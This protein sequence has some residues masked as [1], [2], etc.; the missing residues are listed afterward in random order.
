M[1]GLFFGS[2]NPIHWGHLI[3]ADIIRRE[4][5]LDKIC[6]I[7]SLVSPF[8]SLTNTP[9]HRT[10][11]KL[12]AQ[13]QIK[14]TLLELAL[15]H[16]DK[17]KLLTIEKSLPVPSYT[18]HTLRVLRKNHRRYNKAGLIIGEDNLNYFN[19]WKASAWILNHYPIYI[20]KRQLN[21]LEQATSNSSK[22]GGDTITT[23]TPEIQTM[24][25]KLQKTHPNAKL[26]FSAHMPLLPFSSTVIRSR[27]AAQ[28]SIDHLVPQS[29]NNYIAHHNLYR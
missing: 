6:F 18:Y 11:Q 9:T 29:V 7:P 23:S 20:Y 5:R 10:N 28:K 19:Q 13:F 4:Y 26:N 27:L 16:W 25:K 12:L 15:A 24:I 8:K 3:V 2:F 14:I 1:T 22:P 21:H 17:F